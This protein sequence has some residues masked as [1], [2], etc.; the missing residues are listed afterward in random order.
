[1]KLY[2]H[3]LLSQNKLGLELSVFLVEPYSESHYLTHWK[4][5]VHERIIRQT[6]WLERMKVNLFIF[7]VQFIFQFVNETDTRTLNLRIR[8]VLMH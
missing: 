1:M 5:V 8:A 2:F 4:F 3:T 6:V 7:S